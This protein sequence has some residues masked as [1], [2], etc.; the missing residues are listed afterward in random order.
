MAGE[1]TYAAANPLQRAIRSVASS[2]PGSWVFVRVAR[3]L[4]AGVLTATRGRR[5]LSSLIAG[6][7][8]LQLTTTGAKSGRQRTTTLLG[9]PTE[10]GV[11]I[12]AS[13]FGQK[14]HP[15]WFHNLKA[16]PHC[17]VTIDGVSQEC[18]AVE[19]DG[20]RKARIWQR[21]L[22]IYPGWTEY[23]KRRPSREIAVF[24]LEP[25]STR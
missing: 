11:A 6:I 3:H 7:P 16:H 15:A 1:P 20:E 13:N 21:G 18:R 19:V 23:E 2:R 4:D 22:A 24:V 9:L 5:T 10:G 12:I 8:T 25:A 17:E 14:K